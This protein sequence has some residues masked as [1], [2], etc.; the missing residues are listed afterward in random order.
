[1]VIGLPRDTD[2]L[3]EKDNASKPTNTSRKKPEM[4]FRC[5]AIEDSRSWLDATNTNI[6]TRRN[7]AAN[8]R[9]G[10]VGNPLAAPVADAEPVPLALILN[11]LSIVLLS[12]RSQMVYSPADLRWMLTEPVESVYRTYKAPSGEVTWMKPPDTGVPSDKVKTTFFVSP[13]EPD[14]SAATRYVIGALQTFCT[15]IRPVMQSESM[16]HS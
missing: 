1:M 5:E 12:S 11:S 7:G 15:H 3:V 6:A 4:R 9:S 13:I 8:A 14:E 16:Q 2:G 10:I